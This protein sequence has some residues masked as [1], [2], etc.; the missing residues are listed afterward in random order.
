MKKP[1][2]FEGNF[3]IM[4]Q[5]L[6]WEAS[7]AAPNLGNMVFSVRGRV[8]NIKMVEE[9]SSLCLFFPRH[10]AW[11]HE[12]GSRKLQLPWGPQRAV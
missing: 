11:H 5:I 10:P 1:C 8:E 9:L 12:E 7:P 2:G 3:L 6:V 4:D